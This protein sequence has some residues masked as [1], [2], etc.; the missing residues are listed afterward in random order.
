MPLFKSALVAALISLSSCSSPQVV[1][2]PAPAP[3]C[4]PGAFPK[5]PELSPERCDDG[6]VQLVCMTPADAAAIWA[7][8]RDVGR[9]SERVLVCTDDD[10]PVLK[11]I[12]DLG[13]ILFG[14]DTVYRLP[15]LARKIADPRVRIDVRLTH[16]GF[17]N[18]F[19]N[20]LDETIVFCAEMLEH[21]PGA[22]RFFLAHEIAH[23]YV[24]QLGLP[25]TGSDE[26]SADELAAYLLIRA[27][28]GDDLEDA[29]QFFASQP[30]EIPSFDD[31]PGNMQ[32][33]WTLGCLGLNARG[34]TRPFCRNDL[35]RVQRNWARILK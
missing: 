9:W 31:H 24:V 19:Y 2:V 16:C 30:G 1:Q 15:E 32:R 6:E 17:E 28:L 25:T 14:A 5:F 11:L 18:A 20:P 23:A 29:A 4:R 3:V 22:V 7:W 21:A 34:L 13:D 33:A 10:A 35:A 27:G 8:Q 26:V 12:P